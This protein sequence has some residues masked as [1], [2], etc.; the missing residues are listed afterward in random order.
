MKN[1]TMCGYSCELCKAY[2]PNIKKLDQREMLSKIWM[3]YYNL[4]IKPENIYCDGC[5]CGKEDAKRIDDS[6][7]VRSC[8]LE[9]NLEHCG[10][11]NEY[12]CDTFSEREGLS[13]Q[14]AKENPTFSQTEYDEFLLAFDNKTRLD[15]F[16][17]NN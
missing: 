13:C 16:K 10:C 12:P 11:C 7:P 5:R 8:V 14:A 1:L 6:C 15:E 17:K 4:D 9:K 2:A 3:K